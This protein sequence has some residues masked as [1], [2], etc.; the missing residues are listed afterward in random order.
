MIIWSLNR[1]GIESSMIHWSC[2]SNDRR[3]LCSIECDWLKPKFFGKETNPKW[4][5][6][7]QPILIFKVINFQLNFMDLHIKHHDGTWRHRP[8]KSWFFLFFAFETKKQ[9]LRMQHLLH[10]NSPDW[11]KCVRQ[12]PFENQRIQRN[13]QNKR[14][15][16][17]ITQK[18]SELNS[19]FNQN[20]ETKRTMKRHKN[21]YWTNNELIKIHK[22]LVKGN[23]QTDRKCKTFSSSN[24]IGIDTVH[25]FRCLINQ[26]QM[27][28]KLQRIETEWR[29]PHFI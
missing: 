23:R 20:T 11:H 1:R 12:M 25:G 3:W 18:K 21:F 29:N 28:N 27:A 5:I 26:N 7:V 13:I 8:I 19:V 16:I 9:F 14:E 24:A 10:F 6:P 2:Q 4:V 17:K 15:K 22:I